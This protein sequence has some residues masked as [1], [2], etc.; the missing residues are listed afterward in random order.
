[1]E[2]ACG[3]HDP[4]PRLILGEVA[5]EIAPAAER[6]VAAVVP[7]EEALV[8]KLLAMV[9]DCLQLLPGL[10]IALHALF[11]LRDPPEIEPR[12]VVAKLV[13]RPSVAG[14]LDPPQ[15]SEKRLPV[16]MPHQ[17]PSILFCSRTLASVRSIPPD[18]S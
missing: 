6:D 13:E 3:S 14:V 15:R 2:R 5:D 1:M 10:Q 16:L 4:I 18:R 8:A 17:S 7:S 12:D 9:E 11:E